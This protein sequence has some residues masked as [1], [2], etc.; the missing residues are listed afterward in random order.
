MDLNFGTGGNVTPYNFTVPTGLG[1]NDTGGYGAL[2]SFGLASPTSGAQSPVSGLG[3]VNPGATPGQLGFNLPTFQLGLQG[4]SSLA[5]LYTGLKSL[6]LAQDQF[7][8][9]KDMTQKNYAN[10]LASYNTA[11]TDRATARA[12]TEGQSNATR[13][14]YIAAN[15]LG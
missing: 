8:F 12:V 6:G 2:S 7:N 9:Q 10:S 3:G 4:V 13:D 5:Q 15:K 11:L 1:V 14:A